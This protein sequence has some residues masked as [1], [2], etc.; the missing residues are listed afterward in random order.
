MI[1][2]PVHPACLDQ[3]EMRSIYSTEA[4]WSSVRKTSN[5]TTCNKV[6]HNFGGATPS[7]CIRQKAGRNQDCCWTEHWQI[8][9]NVV[10]VVEHASPLTK[11]ITQ[12]HSPKRGGGKIALLVG[13]HTAGPVISAVGNCFVV[14]LV[15]G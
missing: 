15:V 14:V 3:G 8:W 10:V 2:S 12:T 9:E 7:R 4:E 6:Q 13:N 11:N 5:K 1:F